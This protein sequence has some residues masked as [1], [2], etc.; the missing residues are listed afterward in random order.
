MPVEILKR[1][2]LP[3]LRESLSQVH[4][5]DTQADTDML[6]R[7]ASDFHKRL[8]FEELFMLELGLAVMKKGNTVEKGIMFRP[9]EKLLKNLLAL[10]PFRLTGA[11]E[12]VFDEIYSDMKKPFPM[13][14]L[15][16]GDVGCGKTVVAS[17]GD[18][19]CG[20]MRLPG[21]HYGADGDPR[22][23]AL[24]QHPSNR[25]GPG[26]EGMPPHGEQQRQAA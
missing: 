5:P 2:A 26:V 22:R 8:S 4:F 18:D 14:R 6:N 17:D 25:G 15:I 21:R 1:N 16:Q 10:L 9:G 20:G 24:Y 7:G 13:N 3:G 12:R 11:Q 23:T 19:G